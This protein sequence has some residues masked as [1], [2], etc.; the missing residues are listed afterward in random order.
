MDTTFLEKIVKKQKDSLDYIKTAGII[1]AVILIIFLSFTIE[2]LVTFIPILLIGSIWGA[3]WLLNGLNKEYEY[4]VTENFID[5]DCIIARR[6]R[7][8]VFSGDAKEFEICARVNTDYFTDYSKGSRKILNFAPTHDQNVNYF[9]VTRDNAK[10]SQTK[11]QTVLVIFEPDDRM[12]P[13]FRKYNPS[14]VKVHGMF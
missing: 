11:G 1:S 13:S 10:K 3:W 8:R 4:S 7:T 2:F 6:K 12:V 5:I 9:I 14:K